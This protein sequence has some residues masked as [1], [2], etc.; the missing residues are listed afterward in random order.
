MS[1]CDSRRIDPAKVVI[2]RDSRGLNTRCTEKQGFEQDRRCEMVSPC[3]LYTYWL[4][5]PYDGLMIVD[6]RDGPV[7]QHH[8]GDP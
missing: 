6:L 7:R 3:M 4:S 5:E 1:R 2:S 8:H